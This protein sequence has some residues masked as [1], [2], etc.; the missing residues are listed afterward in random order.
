MNY[1][2]VNVGVSFKEVL[3]EGFLWAPA[4]YIN[5]KKKLVSSA[6]WKHVPEMKKGDIVFC[7]KDKTLI[8][9]GVVKEDGYS[10]LRPDSRKFDA[11][12][13]DGY[14]VEID[15]FKL[16]GGVSTDTFKDFFY[17]SFNDNCDPKVINSKGDFCEQY[18]AKL[19][20]EAGIY[21]LSLI[22]VY[23]DQVVKA[24][25]TL[26]ENDYRSYAL[27]YK[28]G[29]SWLLEKENLA[30]KKVDK[31]LKEQGWT[32]IPQEI[33][34][35][36]VG[37][38]LKKNAETTVTLCV[39]GKEYVTSVKRRPDGR[40]KLALTKVKS[41]LKMSHLIVDTDKV[42]FERDIEK[43]RYF[44]VYTYSIKP[45]NSVPPKPSLK[46]KPGSTT[47]KTNSEARIGQDYFKAAVSEVCKGRCV[48]TGVKDQTP[49]ILIG[50]HTKSWADS[51]DEER[52]D[53]HNGLLLAPHIDKLFDR[54][55]ISFSESGYMLVSKNLD[56][57]VL[58]AW[59]INP[60][61]QLL[62]TP[63]QHDYMS[64]HRAKFREKCL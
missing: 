31:T 12:K 59:G 53:G 6:G 54:H 57:S 17:R 36:F 9:V 20:E 26:I 23:R 24:S 64:F 35:F 39:D 5:D 56:E 55:L 18:L 40:H 42:W 1:F 37:S 46:S 15:V 48:V 60:N 61:K 22:E 52:M 21:L 30:V 10:A 8:Y 11:W 3:Q 44:Y 32:G 14:K 50:S 58:L 51:N 33:V 34:S 19:P 2:W 7:N 45:S 62:L 47:R 63:K 49:S 28:A 4:P 29:F 13:R 38:P 25:E 41:K 43:R 16:I 27:P